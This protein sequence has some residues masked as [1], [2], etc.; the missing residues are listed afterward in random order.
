MKTKIILIVFIL[1]FL[2]SFRP[3]SK[4]VLESKGLIQ[5]VLDT[6][7]IAFIIQ[8]IPSENNRDV[9]EIEASKNGKI[10][11]R[12]NNGISIATAFNWYLKEVAHLSYD[13]Q[14]DKPLKMA[15]VMPLPTTK[16][17]RSCGA[18]E[19]FFN[20]TC[21]FGYTFAYWD[22]DR[23]QRFIDWLAMNGIN[24]PLM[25]SGQEAVWLK[26]WE[27]FGMTDTEVLTYFSAPAHL[28]W[29]RM[30]NM[31]KWGGPLPLSYIEGQQGLQQQIL[32]RSRALGMKPILSAFAGH[33][34]E[35]LKEL[36][37]GA[38]ISRIIPGW[39]GMDATYTTYFL[40]PTDKLFGEIQKR[41]L[42]EQQKL[43]G[44]D[45]LYSADP[46]NEITPPSWEP[47]YLAKVGKTIYET[48][49]KTDQESSWY[50]MSWTFYYDR[51][52][53]TQPRLAAMIHAVPKDKLIFLDYVCEEEEYFR[54]SNYF[55]G[56][57]FIWCY[58]G[59]FGGNTHLVAPMNKVSKRLS[60]LPVVPNCVG[61]GST[62]EGINVN[63]EIYELTFEMP[64][65]SDESFNLDKWIEDYAQRRS[66]SYDEAVSDAWQMLRQDILVDSAVGIWNHSVVFQIPPVTDLNKSSWRGRTYIPYK[67]AQLAK[68]ISR[69][70]QA[71]NLSKSSDSYQFDLV[72]LTRQA[73]GN[74]GC[75]LY[76]HMMQAY[77]QKN[78]P[79]F[80]NYSGRFITLG[81]EIDSLLA[82]RHE[83][84]LGRWLADARHWGK[85]STEH[86]YYE[87]DA[88]E[89]ITT[90]HKAGGGLL[91]Y[92]NRQWN[93]L[94]RTYYLP[95]WV[96][97]IN[98]LDY[99]LKQDKPFDSKGF[100][101][102]CTS[103][104]QN[105]VDS[106]SN[107]FLEKETGNA[108]EYSYKLFLKYQNELLAD[109]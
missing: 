59:N 91:D 12:G 106:P 44:T 107:G 31:D 80:R 94:M 40:D 61:V 45:H 62:L 42:V 99:S 50:Q 33:V 85:N 10:I 95:R 90:W 9:F 37:P 35:S 108:V 24:R 69:M 96:E 25:L 74:F 79:E 70:L 76:H 103:F 18:K 93:G 88:R 100:A 3:E 52:H 77:E 29:H 2:F 39:G 102:W 104:E 20:N 54:K 7:A 101:G 8:E 13:W 64:W 23:W 16:I 56:A 72:N 71:N 60:V 27:S 83:F 55:H 28:P 105:W 67:N 43:Y 46:F 6:T 48:M 11:L 36:Y 51:T 26:V 34:P 87:R 21:T 49:F 78:I 97:F 86:N 47:D 30:A 92:S 22:W 32:A 53:W 5:R 1:P 38:K 58:L 14:A 19:R 82:T 15:K 17:H 63:P 109:N 81:M 98:Q 66:G 84:L 89:I 75:T 57:P 41:F 68:A 73:L 65:R 4:A